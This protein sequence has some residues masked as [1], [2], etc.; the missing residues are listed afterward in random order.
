MDTVDKLV[1]SVS[2]DNKE[3][4]DTLEKSTQVIENFSKGAKESLGKVF[5]YFVSYEAVN[6][7]KNL[8]EGF[9]STGSNLSYLSQTLNVSA[10]DLSTWQEAA[11]RTGGSA[12]SLNGTIHTMYNRLNMMRFNADPQMATLLSQLN[13]NP[14]DVNGKQKDVLKLT[15]EVGEALSK[16]PQRTAQPMAQ[17]LGW[18]DASFRLFTQNKQALNSLLVDVQK[19]GVWSNVGAEHAR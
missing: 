12:E 19:S 14:L 15:R 9:A 10:H 5:D 11:K 8:A 13:V 18:D 16:L 2:L 7:V 17:M 3:L 1:V 6:Y 4:K